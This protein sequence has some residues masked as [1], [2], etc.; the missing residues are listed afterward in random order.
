RGA[1]L[2]KGGKAI[3]ALPSRTQKGVSR[4]TPFL[5]QGG[6]VVT[7]RAHVHYV[8]TEHGIAY[9][10]GKNLRERARELIRIAHPDDRELLEQA[11]R[12]RF[13]RWSD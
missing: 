4:I 12:D 8:V 3:I 6:G 1:A 9:L 7:T 2:S 13:G 11:A 10:F 5:K